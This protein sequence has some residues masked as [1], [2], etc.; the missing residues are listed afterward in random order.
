[1]PVPHAAE[2][3]EYRNG[4]RRNSLKTD[5]GAFIQDLNVRFGIIC[6]I[7]YLIAL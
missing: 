2:I 1:M 7:V 3:K 5:I 4:S 6:G